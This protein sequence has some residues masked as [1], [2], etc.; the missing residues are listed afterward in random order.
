MRAEAPSTPAP[1]TIKFFLHLSDDE[2]LRRFERRAEI[3]YKR[4]KLTEEDWRNREKRDQ[5]EDAINDMVARTSTGIAPWHLVSA[6]EKNHTRLTVLETV[7][8]EIEKALS[9]PRKSR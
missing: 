5:Y 3:P 7:S 8:D 9:K 6:N 1:R 4:W 2:Q